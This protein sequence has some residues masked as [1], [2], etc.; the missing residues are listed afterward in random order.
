MNKILLTFLVIFFP[1]LLLSQKNDTVYIAFDNQYEEMEKSNFTE[2]VQAGS[3]EEKLEKS[4][5]YLIRQMEEDTYGATRFKFFHSNQSQKTY[6]K[7]G[8]KPPII[9]K[10][11]KS[12]LQDKKLLG[13]EFFR[14]T[15]YIKVAKTFE[16]EDSWEEDVMI[17]MI[18]ADE[19]KNDS[20]ILRQVSFTRP[21]K[22]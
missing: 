20:I 8:G 12:F 5:A 9:L 13:I 19:I 11:H 10:K 17:F 6:E 15:P 2:G 1:F 3:P 14:T 22:E 16:E 7:F 21:V 4:M 18:D